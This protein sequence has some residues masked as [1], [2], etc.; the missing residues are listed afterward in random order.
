M[1]TGQTRPTRVVRFITPDSIEQAVLQL[2]VRAGGGIGR[3]EQ[4]VL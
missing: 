3:G 2:Q 4:A 1:H